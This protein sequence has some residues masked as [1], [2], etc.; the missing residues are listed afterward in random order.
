MTD[1]VGAWLLTPHLTSPLPG[2]RD[3]ILAV[4]RRLGGSARYPWRASMT[5]LWTHAR[6]ALPVVPLAQAVDAAGDAEE[7]GS[8]FVTGYVLGDV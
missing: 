2:G 8:V 7:W 4:E 3:E 1:G 6:S 5:E